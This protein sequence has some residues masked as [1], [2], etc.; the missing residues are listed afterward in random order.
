LPQIGGP[1]I[2]HAVLGA[3]RAIGAEY[4]GAS[5]PVIRMSCTDY[6]LGS[7]AA[8]FHRCSGADLAPRK[9]FDTERDVDHPRNSIRPTVVSRSL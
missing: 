3:E 5:V 8:D 9:V 7:N 6:G 2:D 4:R 1:W